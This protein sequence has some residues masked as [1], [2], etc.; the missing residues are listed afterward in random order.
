M[1]M[2]WKLTPKA[3][4]TRHPNPPTNPH[5]DTL[6]YI[7]VHLLSTYYHA[8]GSIH[9]CL[10]V[11]ERVWCCLE[12]ISRLWSTYVRT[13]VHTHTHSCSNNINDVQMA[14]SCYDF[15]KHPHHKHCR[16]LKALATHIDTLRHWRPDTNGNV[17]S[18]SL[19]MRAHTHTPSRMAGLAFVSCS[20]E[21]FTGA[22][23]APTYKI[24]S[25]ELGRGVT[26][27]AVVGVGGR[28]GGNVRW[29]EW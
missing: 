25:C 19:L 24:C 28:G 5:T 29:V 15:V 3:D 10:S 18:L 8:P 16:R 23:C 1:Y 2:H 17:H 9:V 14:I 21:Q 4:T 13:H 11:C 22:R 26:C 20:Q 6:T 7:Q 27:Q 12:C